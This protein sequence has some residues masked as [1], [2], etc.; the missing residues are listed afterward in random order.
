MKNLIQQ[1]PESEKREILKSLVDNDQKLTPEQKANIM[2][3]LQDYSND[4]VINDINRLG[5][6]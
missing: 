2:A 3:E 6:F 1:L 5:N 4:Q